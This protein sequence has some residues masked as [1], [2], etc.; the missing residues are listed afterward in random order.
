MEVKRF[1]GIALGILLVAIGLS[2][3]VPAWKRIEFWAWCYRNRIP[4][5]LFLLT[6]SLLGV[7]FSTA[8][9]STAQALLNLGLDIA[10][11]GL[12][13]ITLAI[14]KIQ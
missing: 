7:A 5:P 4:C 14:S 9:Y 13:L 8:N 11:L 12:A 10:V 1:A 3:A 2:I 6:Y